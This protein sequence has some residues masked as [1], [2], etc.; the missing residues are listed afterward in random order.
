MTPEKRAEQEIPGWGVTHFGQWWEAS[1]PTFAHD[2]MKVEAG[3][4]EELVDR[5]RNVECVWAL[6]LDR[7]GKHTAD[8]ASVALRG[9]AVAPITIELEPQGPEGVNAADALGVSTHLICI[10]CKQPALRQDGACQVCTACGAKL[11]GCG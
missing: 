4:L 7:L 11:G 6:A 9:W 8:R 5:V 3:S 10:E 2:G 1:S